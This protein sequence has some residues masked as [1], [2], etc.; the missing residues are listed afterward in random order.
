MTIVNESKTMNKITTR[1]EIPATGIHF[2]KFGAEWCG[3]CKMMK[4]ILNSFE[5]EGNS[6]FDIDIDSAP[7]LT[8]EFQIKSVPT[9]VVV[10]D[11]LMVKRVVGLL[12]LEK[13]RGLMDDAPT[14]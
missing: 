7:D 4:P 13:L 6:V 5:E 1:E 2:V 8:R 3:P 10:K 14:G 12:P 9:I 11:G